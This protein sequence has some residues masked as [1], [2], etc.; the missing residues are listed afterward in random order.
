MK[1]DLISILYT[2]NYSSLAQG[3]QISLYYILR[4]IDR[5]KYKPVLACTM[6]GNLTAKAR[7]LGIEVELVTFP[8]GM[9]PWYF[10]D[11][12]RFIISLNKIIDKYGITIVHC[13]ELTV[14]CMAFFIKLF[15]N[16]K[17]IWHVRVSWN[18][19]FQKKIG[20]IVSSAVICVSRFV[21]ES[22]RSNSNKINVICNGINADEFSPEGGKTESTLF[23]D[24]DIL[25][26]QIG[27]L[28]DN[29]Q[30][31][32]LIRAVA[33]VLKSNPRVKLILVGK[34]SDAYI[35][36]L[37]S[38]AQELHI[39]NNVIFWGEE[40]N[41]KPLLKRIDIICLL[42][43]KEGLSR[44]LLE[45]MALAKTI[46]ASNIAQNRELIIHRKTGLNAMVGSPEDTA[47]Q[48]NTA[49][50]DRSLSITL[51]KT[52][53]RYVIENFSLTD[54]ITRIQQLYVRLIEKTHE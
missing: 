16:I 6:E 23:N 32:V 46:V 9:R 34:G 50:A 29:K 53:R 12:L 33:I 21:A 54:T 28:V 39:E 30:P 40:N 4:D 36:Y 10:I 51:G 26:G 49:L 42:S 15:R 52:A 27:S 22:F 37:N 47:L 43:R 35:Q 41:I 1:Q 24:E 17:T 7:E 19:S 25:V 14:V 38:V 20:L 13:D 45:A 8:A 2:T 48:I 11:I 44:T 31:D 18:T 3:G 5:T